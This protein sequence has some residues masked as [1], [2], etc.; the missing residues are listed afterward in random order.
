MAHKSPFFTKSYETHAFSSLSS[1][2]TA[3]KKRRFQARI[4]GCSFNTSAK[5]SAFLSQNRGWLSLKNRWQARSRCAPQHPTL[6]GNRHSSYATIHR[7]R[8]TGQMAAAVL[9]SSSHPDSRLS[10]PNVVR[11]SCS[12]SSSSR[13]AAGPFNAGVSSNLAR[14]GGTSQS[15]TGDFP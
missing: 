7:S 12:T 5:Q 13:P 11:G 14:T 10:R 3:R 15:P 6:S 1:L 4:E 2:N 9:K 8:A